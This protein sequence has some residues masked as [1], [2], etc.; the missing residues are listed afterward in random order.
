MISKRIR[1]SEQLGR[2]TFAAAE[3]SCSGCQ[4]SCAGKWFAPRA[5]ET[6]AQGQTFNDAEVAVSSSGLNS[7]VAVLFGLPLLLL[8]GLGAA[9]ETFGMA[10]T[11]LLSL[12]AIV[13]ALLLI[14]TVLTRYGTKLI[15][16]LRVKVYASSAAEQK[17]S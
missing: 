2:K 16:L 15:P 6:G 17:I 4:Q 1:V 11:P 10:A 5:T 7:V 14:G 12:T 3:Q 13:T 9:F 8:L